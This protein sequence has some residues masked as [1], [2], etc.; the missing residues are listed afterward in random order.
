MLS[1]FIVQSL[2]D[3]RLISLSNRGGSKS[4]KPDN[5]IKSWKETI[6]LGLIQSLHLSFLPN[7]ISE[8]LIVQHADASL[9]VFYKLNHL[10]Q[11]NNPSSRYISVFDQNFL[12]PSRS[13][14]VS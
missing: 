10:A 4:S 5:A 11:R 2:Y 13:I 3:I 12:T 9:S 8:T 7:E 6:I 1:Q 14:H